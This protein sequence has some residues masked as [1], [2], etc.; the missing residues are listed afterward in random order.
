CSCFKRLVALCATRPTLAPS[1]VVA[2][3]LLCRARAVQHRSCV[4]PA[5]YIVM[6]R[7]S[8]C[9]PSLHRLVPRYSPLLLAPRPLPPHTTL[10]AIGGVAHIVSQSQLFLF[11]V[12]FYVNIGLLASLVAHILNLCSLLNVKS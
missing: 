4:V 5:S 8:P 1:S 11:F 2:V 6:S 9:R 7:C 3:L 12:I 10:C